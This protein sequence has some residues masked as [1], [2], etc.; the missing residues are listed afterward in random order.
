MTNAKSCNGSAVVSTIAALILLPNLA[1]AP[2]PDGGPPAGGSAPTAAGNPCRMTAE[3][4]TNINAGTTPM[5][6]FVVIGDSLIWGNGLR[7]EEKFRTLVQQWLERDHFQ[8]RRV[9]RQRVWAHSGATIKPDANPWNDP[10]SGDV[11]GSYP[12]IE[13][14]ALCVPD[15]QNVDLI[16]MDGCINDLPATSIVDPTGGRRPVRPLFDPVYKDLGLGR[17]WVDQQVVIKCSPM[18][19]LLTNVLKRF[20]HAKVVVVGYHL[21]FSEK[22]EPTLLPQLYAGW[23]LLAPDLPGQASGWFAGPSLPVLRDIAAANAAQFRESTNRILADAVRQANDADTNRAPSAGPRAVFVPLHA[24]AETA[25][26]AGPLSYVWLIPAPL[27]PVDNMYRDRQ[28]QCDREIPIQTQYVIPANEQCKL[29]AAVHPNVLGAQAYAKAIIQALPALL[30]APPIRVTVTP[31][32]PVQPWTPVTVR[33]NVFDG[34]T[35]QPLNGTVQLAGQSF[36]TNTDKSIT[37]EPRKVPIAPGGRTRLE[38]TFEGTVTVP[39]YEN[40]GILFNLHIP[41]LRVEPVYDPSAARRGKQI[42]IT[43]RA[44]DAETAQPVRGKVI[45]PGYPSPNPPATNQQFMYALPV[46][47]ARAPTG[48]V[49]GSRTEM[50]FVEWWVIADNGH[51][52]DTRVGKQEH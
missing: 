28:Q 22:T 36:S 42:P 19:A 52:S 6:E 44:V 49:A 37:F 32:T 47:V 50:A 1:S 7:P 3:Y 41:T 38:S 34:H 21:L 40:G 35:N 9:V 10:R 18:A 4:K 51:Y 27:G 2:P 20:S 16:L 25:Y 11:G 39:G 12:T 14:Q 15:F 43:V 13:Q 23:A 30:K 26:G 24:E 17:K 31:G 5:F 46:G 48:D 8:Y 29:N 33:V 45:I